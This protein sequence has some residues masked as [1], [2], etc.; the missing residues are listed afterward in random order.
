V[1]L[2]TKGNI[3]RLM[4]IYSPEIV[5]FSVMTPDYPYPK[6]FFELCKLSLRVYMK[7][8]SINEVFDLYSEKYYKKIEKLCK[9]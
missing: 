2:A 1:D 3:Q 8:K 5:G 9:R 6:D 7:R 4:E